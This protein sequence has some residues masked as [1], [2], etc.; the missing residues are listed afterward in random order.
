LHDALRI[1]SRGLPG[2][3]SL[4]RFLA[5]RR[6]VPIPLCCV[7]KARLTVGQ[8]RAWARAHLR[9]TRHWPA[10]HLG[11]IPGARGTT[12]LAVDL[13]L[14][15]GY[16][17]LPGGSSLARVLGKRPGSVRNIHGE[18][19][20]TRKIVRWARAF[21]ARR[22]RWPRENDGKIPESPGDTW[23]AVRSALRYGLRGIRRPMTLA[24]FLHRTCDA[25]LARR[26]GPLTVAQILAWA[27]AFHE[28]TGKW[29]GTQSGPIPDSS[30]EKWKTVNGSLYK[31][32]RGLP[33]G[34]TLGDLLHKH[35]GVRNIRG[36]PPLTRS[37]V[38]KWADAHFRRTGRWPHRQSGT[39]PGSSGETWSGVYD[40]LFRGG[41]GVG[42]GPTLT[43]MLVEKR[44]A[45]LPGHLPRFT[46]AKIILWA[47]AHARRYSEWPNMHSGRIDDAPGESWLRVDSCL[48]RGLRG[49]RGGRSLGIL[50]RG[51]PA[52]RTLASYI[53]ED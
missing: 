10:T 13:A 51:R 4:A 35:R 45:R 19:L 23:V 24:R 47:Q 21:H 22:G 37:L 32:L 43:Q 26:G 36:L 29:P 40:A 28:R 11:V 20:T 46:D 33:Q 50:L 41:R 2:G 12:W 31:G 49:L 42:R 9:R 48:R 27:D 8:I 30:G 6:R 39:I 1:G 25:P 16:R 52:P 15:L 34:L 17:G 5:Q 53:V 18:R 3:T 38:L 44:G 14:R 7:P